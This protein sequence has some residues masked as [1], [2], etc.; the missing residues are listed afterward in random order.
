VTSLDEAV[1]PDG[2]DR[3][4]HAP[5]LA[6]VRGRD[7]RALAADLDADV[8]RAGLRHGVGEHEHDFRIDPVPRVLQ[9]AEWD[10]LAAGVV[11]RVLA[12]EAFAADAHGAR[13][14]VRAGVVPAEV[15][16]TSRYLAAEV[17]TPTAYV[18]M[19]GPDVVRGADGR[20]VVL[21]DNVRTPTMLA[22]A[23]A[24]RDLVGGRLDVEPAPHPVREAAGAAAR[25]ML[26]AA[27][28]V[29]DPVVAV[30]GDGPRSGVAWEITALAELVGAPAVVAED[31]RR[32]G[33]HLLLPDGRPVDVLWRRTSEER[34][35][36]DAGR[37]S[38]LGELLLA[39][40]RA[41]TVAVV[42]AFGSGVADDKR[43][44]CYVE[45]LVRFYRGEEP[46]LRSV[47]SYDLGEPGRLAQVLPR[48]H[49]LVVKPRSG[50]GGH[51]VLIGPRA[52]REQV[53][54]AREVV[55]AEPGEWVAQEL[56]ALSTHP[57]VVDG[58]LVPRHVDLRPFAFATGPGTG[59]RG[60][61]VLPGGFTR[62]ALREGDLVVNASQGG[63]GKDT[64][65]V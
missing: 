64:W 40:L 15:L 55:A 37:L 34:L 56:V 11:Q 65:V 1:A 44:Y 63:G 3:P 41:G 24:A 8:R 52:S 57:T 43:A 48:L 49:E 2:S 21:E 9:Q 16:E 31:L 60:I 50:S 5:A 42:N 61:T 33:D 32:H 29:A 45:E 13:E 25:A 38:D 62:V 51:G 58:A 53:E 20:L 10:H 6:A 19:A 54:R 46:L 39:P 47:P 36:D 12:L 18:G 27:T 30:L 23:L 7:L 26:R 14:A 28:P 22:Y 35:R 59:D 4:H 17:P